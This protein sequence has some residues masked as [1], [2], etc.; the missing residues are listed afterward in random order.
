MSM[1]RTSAAYDQ[2]HKTRPCAKLAC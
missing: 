1:E 2:K